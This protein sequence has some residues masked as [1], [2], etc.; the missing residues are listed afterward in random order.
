MLCTSSKKQILD[1]NTHKRADTVPS[2]LVCRSITQPF[3]LS[4]FLICKLLFNFIKIKKS[5]KITKSFLLSVHSLFFN[6]WSHV[7]F[8]FMIRLSMPWFCF[9]LATHAVICSSLSNRWPQRSTIPTNQRATSDLIPSDIFE[10]KEK[11]KC[12][13]ITDYQ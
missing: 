1:A 2:H 7:R 5:L 10:N 6:W 4:S 12:L 9:G 11:R 8:F 13:L 3:S